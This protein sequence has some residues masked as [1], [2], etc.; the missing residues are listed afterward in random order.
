MDKYPHRCMDTEG[1]YLPCPPS[2]CEADRLSRPFWIEVEGTTVIQVEKG[3]RV[4]KSYRVDENTR[5]FT[6]EPG[7]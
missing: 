1:D 5:R 3:W 6:L 2:L 4:R 7:L